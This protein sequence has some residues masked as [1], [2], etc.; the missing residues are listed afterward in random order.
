MSQ[1]LSGREASLFQSLL[2]HY[3]N[4]ENKKALKTADEILKTVPDHGETL[5][6]K[7][8]IMSFEGEKDEGL[9]TIKKGLMKNMK[10]HVC[11][12]ILG[13]Y[14]K[15]AMNFTEA[16]KCYKQALKFDKTNN[17]IL[18]DLANLQVHTRDLEGFHET[19]RVMLSVKTDNLVNWLTYSVSAHL[20][21][22][23]EL[24]LAILQNFFEFQEKPTKPSSEY[25]EVLLYKSMLLEEKGQFEECIKFMEDNKKYILDK[26]GM[27]ER[28]ARALLKIGK[29]NE[30]IQVISELMEINC[31]NLQYHHFLQ[32]ARGLRPLK[33]GKE[34]EIVALYEELVK[35]YPKSMLC[36]LIYLSNLKGDQLKANLDK[37]LK[38][39]L[40][41]GVPALFSVMRPLLKNAEAFK[42]TEELVNGY[43]GSLTATKKLPGSE[44]EELPTVLI[45]CMNFSAQMLSRKGLNKEA[46]D[47]IEKAISHTP[48]LPD[49]YIIRAKIYRRSGNS[50]LAADSYNFARKLDLYDR[51]LNTR[52]CKYL[53]RDNRIQEA[54]DVHGLFMKAT[55]GP[56]P[57]QI[58]ENQSCMFEYEMGCSYLRQGIY[59]K[60]LKAFH[61]I[62]S[63]YKDMIEDQFDFHYYN[64]R[65]FN[66]C[67]YVNLLRHEDTVFSHKFYSK[68]ALKIIQIHNTLSEKVLTEEVIAEKKKEKEAKLAEQAKLKE[69]LKPSTVR[70]K[71]IPPDTDPEGYN[72][73]EVEDHLA[74]CTTYVEQLERHL[75]IAPVAPVTRKFPAL[76][77]LIVATDVYL[78][79]KKYFLSFCSLKKAF[80]LA[81]TDSHVLASIAKFSTIVTP[82]L[83]SLPDSVRGLIESGLVVLH[84]S[85]STSTTSK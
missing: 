8:L 85:S 3:E 77:L 68:A 49:L 58:S 21:G 17:Q 29:T 57:L 59:G 66:L 7:G 18:R 26:L 81:P 70:G 35:K 78:K 67:N 51:S 31:N 14:H 32:E 27:R 37:F 71:T 72:L 55:D 48:T 62:E 19:R 54:Y 13:I 47:L 30:A 15:T 42:F 44:T 61:S 74:V 45:W 80:D 82:E 38:E 10:S 41:K 4:K 40:K 28:R 73:V 75:K 1:T 39:K 34:A 56:I 11:W 25:S 65:K 22:N 36:T 50:T 24:A 33:E 16:I 84:G 76:D 9:A 12:H 79:R 6:M 69:T 83:A 52:C 20:I 5:S 23:I 63:H 43:I 46:L 60:A 64:F 53:L 2:R